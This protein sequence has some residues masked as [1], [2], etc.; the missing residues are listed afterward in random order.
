MSKQYSPGEAAEKCGVHKDTISGAIRNGR[1]K[2]TL[3]PIIK[4]EYRITEEDLSEWQRK[5]RPGRP[6]KPR[7]TTD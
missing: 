4:Y 5:K 3:V 6:L 1:L 7:P 2:A